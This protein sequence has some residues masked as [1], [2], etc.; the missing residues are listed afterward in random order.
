MFGKV[1]FFKLLYKYIIL[2]LVVSTYQYDLL[3]IWIT[4]FLFNFKQKNAPTI[5]KDYKITFKIFMKINWFSLLINVMFLVFYVIIFSILPNKFEYSI[6]P[7]IPFKK[8]YE[9]ICF[10]TPIWNIAVI[11]ALSLLSNIKHKEKYIKNKFIN[12]K[13]NSFV[14]L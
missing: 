3:K 2:S 9:F 14:K 11:I 10:F 7:F 6:I 1:N 4:T 12:F 13:E 5:K 8:M